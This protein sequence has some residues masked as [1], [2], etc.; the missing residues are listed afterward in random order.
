M[1]EA[2]KMRHRKKLFWNAK[3]KK[4]QTDIYSKTIRKTVRKRSQFAEGAGGWGDNFEATE[5]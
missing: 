2:Q 5:M 4:K 1:F 3:K